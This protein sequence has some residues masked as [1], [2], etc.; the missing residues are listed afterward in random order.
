MNRTFTPGELRGE[1]APGRDEP[2]FYCLDLKDV[3]RDLRIFQN[4]TFNMFQVRRVKSDWTQCCPNLNIPILL[5]FI[6]AS[7]AYI[8]LL[9]V[10]GKFCIWLHDVLKLNHGRQVSRVS[11]YV[12]LINQARGPYWENI[13]PRS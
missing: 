6:I 12:Y 9:S 2:I 11:Q 10:E 1:N 7:I 5:W 3:P 4:I 13:G 8:Y